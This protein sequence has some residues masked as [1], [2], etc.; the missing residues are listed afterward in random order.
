MEHI[1]SRIQEVVANPGGDKPSSTEKGE[2]EVVWG[3]ATPRHDLERILMEREASLKELEIKHKQL[4]TETVAVQ[5]EYGAYKAKVQTW[6]G[7][8]VSMSGRSE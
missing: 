3:P 1:F 4:K 8:M 2:S 7:H 6:R 5:E